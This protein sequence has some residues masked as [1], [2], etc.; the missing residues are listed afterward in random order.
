MATET[1]D[2]EGIARRLLEERTQLAMALVDE[3]CVD[4]PGAQERLSPQIKAN[5]DELM[6]LEPHLDSR[7]DVGQYVKRLRSQ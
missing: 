7:S 6:A 4:V 2:Y 3:E 5:Y 1:P